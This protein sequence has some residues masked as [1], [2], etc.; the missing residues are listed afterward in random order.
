LQILQAGDPKSGQAAKTDT[1]LDKLAPLLAMLDK[2]D[3]E[4]L[5]KLKKLLGQMESDT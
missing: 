3:L 4:S 1:N 2:L 5:Q